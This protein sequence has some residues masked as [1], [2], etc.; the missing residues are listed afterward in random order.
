MFV[1]SE[2]FL[3]SAKKTHNAYC[4]GDSFVRDVIFLWV[5][6]RR[7]VTVFDLVVFAVDS[8]AS[9]SVCGPGVGL[10]FSDLRFELV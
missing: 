1:I 7:N 10:W 4:L 3:A 9:R 6:G 8:A 5:V 2:I